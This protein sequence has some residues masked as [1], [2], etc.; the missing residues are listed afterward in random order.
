MH[1]H[2]VLNSQS[3]VVTCKGQTDRYITGMTCEMHV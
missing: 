3:H 2:K 1:K